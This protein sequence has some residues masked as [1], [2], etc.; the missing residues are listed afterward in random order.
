MSF[1]ATSTD[2]L[3]S[4][5]TATERRLTDLREQRTPLVE[6][7]SALGAQHPLGGQRV[8]ATVSG[9]GAARLALSYEVTGARWFPTYDIQLTPSRNQVAIA[10]VGLVAQDTGEDWTGTQLTLS[11][12]IPAESSKFP[13]LTAW[14]IGSSERFVPSPQPE[15]T[16][17]APPPPPSPPTPRAFDEVQRL[18]GLLAN[19]AAGIG[20][21]PAGQP[22]AEEAANRRE[23]TKQRSSRSNPFGAA[24]ANMVEA[25]PAVVTGEDDADTMMALPQMVKSRHASMDASEE[26]STEMLASKESSSRAIRPAPRI[27]VNIAPPPAY[28]Y[29]RLAANLP[30]ALA[31]GHDLTFPSAAR[32]TIASGKGA[33][34]VALFSQTWPVS[35][36]RLIFPALAK[37]AFLVAA[38]KNP[39]KQA[40]PG[41][42][43]NLFVGDDSAGVAD[44][45]F[46]APGEMFTLPLG[47]DQAIKPIRNVTQTT[48]ETGLISKDEVTEYTTVIEFANP[49]SSP[50]AVRVKDQIPVSADKD[51]AEVRLLGSTPAAQLT[52]E[53][54]ALEWQM[55]VPAG[56]TVKLR[57]VYSIK[58]PKGARLVQQ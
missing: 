5:L 28:R 6:K 49:H 37:E 48:S 13:R 58:R 43:A 51:R 31:A 17:V 26:E 2:G 36:E 23:S 33:R 15:P 3:Q 11:T 29:P 54:G 53:N 1:L 10:F 46:V 8:V 14:R 16:T 55:T 4:R 45:K 30:A 32:E 27:P 22:K 7:A 56:A 44:L 18:R 20:R 47:I 9:Q 21:E 34:R 24:D 19:A 35:V 39:S 38:F 42:R 52:A 50:L 57:F 12:A 40:M 41:G 25:S